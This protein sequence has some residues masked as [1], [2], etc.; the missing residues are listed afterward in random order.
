L[1]R[2][3]LIRRT[4]QGDDVRQAMLSAIGEVERRCRATVGDDRYESFLDVLRV[5][6]GVRQTS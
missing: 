5:F 6:A 4:R 2:A 3:K 1:V